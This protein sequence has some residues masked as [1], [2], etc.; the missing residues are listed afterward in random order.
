MAGKGG[1]CA[2]L[3]TSSSRALPSLSQDPSIDQL[4]DEYQARI[5]KIEKEA[6]DKLNGIVREGLAT[7]TQI[8]QEAHEKAQAE[9]ANAR[10]EI[11]KTKRKALDDL[12]GEMSR[13][14]LETVEKVLNQK[15]D[16]AE[17]GPLVERALSELDT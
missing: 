2:L 17:Y 11:L 12:R 6:S 4:M 14:T 5:A 10:A 16:P 3:S 15:V 8:L 13:L 7:K 9:L 1:L